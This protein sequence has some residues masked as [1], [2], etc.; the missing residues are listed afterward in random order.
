MAQQ[1]PM[2][3]LS[4]L[5]LC[6]SLAT[7]QAATFVLS[8]EN[9]DGGGASGNGLNGGNAN[10]SVSTTVGDP[11]ASGRGN[12]GSADV[13]AGGRWGE[14]RAQTQTIGIPAEST[15]GTDTFTASLDIFVPKATT[16]NGSHRVGI[17]LRW[18]GNNTNNNQVF[19]SWDSFSSDVWETVTLTGT[20]PVN[21][22]DGQPL[23]SVVPII[24][25]DE[26]PQNAAPGVAA[27]VDNWSLSVTGVPEPSLG[28][29]AVLG[30]GV[31]LL[32]RR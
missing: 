16:F 30:M 10:V 22:G 26:N 15:P 27:Y 20:L 28:I 8:D 25:F 29:L 7:T 24:S 31:L 19:R 3:S 21:G 9:F 12:L 17:I 2:K 32:R 23:T 14:V 4:A 13:S 18:N 6:I 5:F 1:L 11:T